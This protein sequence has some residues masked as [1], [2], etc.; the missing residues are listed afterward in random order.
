MDDQGP[1]PS[2]RTHVDA[3]E[4]DS[5]LAAMLS[6]SG[7]LGYR[8]V[9]VELIAERS[10]HS[11][12]Y[13]YSRFSSREECFAVAYEERAAP[14]LARILKA[15]REGADFAEGIRAG[16]GELFTFVAAEPSIARALLT[17]V[18]VADGDAKVRHEQN[19]RRLSDAVAGTRRETRASRHDSPP[20]AAAFIV[21]GL[22]EAVRRRLVEGRPQ[23]LWEELPDLVAFATA[24]LL[25]GPGAE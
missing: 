1:A 2:N 16:L 10:G 19:L 12:S 9:T 13:L 23:L 24:H 25:E 15:G 8:Q 6:L 18:Y 7:E 22:E 17:E 3:P 20:I 21:G 4:R 5:L 14:L 11:A